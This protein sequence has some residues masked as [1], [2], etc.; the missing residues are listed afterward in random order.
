M[1]RSDARAAQTYSG[2]AI[3]PTITVKNGTTTLKNGTDYTVTYSNNTKVG[4]ATVTITGKGNYI[5]TI[6]KTFT[7]TAQSISKSATVSNV[8]TK[9]YNGKAQTQ[10]PTVKIGTKTLVNG[11]DYTVSYTSNTDVGKARMVIRG[12]GNYSGA[13]VKYFN[14]NPRKQTMKRITAG[15][16]SFRAVWTKVSEATG[17]QLEYSTSSKF[18]NSTK[19]WITSKT[20]YAKTISKLSAKKTYYVRVRTYT[21]VGTTK[22][23]GAW[24]TAMSVKTK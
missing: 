18:T 15:T 19:T 3:K 8:V 4:T 24:S 23:Y 20:S 17:Y 16:K 21:K 22:Y 12:K 7:I 9:T 13:I 1:G 11:T 14:I 5:G 10:N 6:T 2:S